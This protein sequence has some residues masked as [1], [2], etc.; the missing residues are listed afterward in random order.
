MGSMDDKWVRDIVEERVRKL[1]SDLAECLQ[2]VDSRLDSLEHIT[3]PWKNDSHG[4]DVQRKRVY[5]LNEQLARALDANGKLQ[6]ERDAA[7][8]RVKELEAQDDFL[9]VADLEAHKERIARELKQEHG[10]E[11]EKLRADLNASEKTNAALR[12][13]AEE[14]EARA[15]AAERTLE[16]LKNRIRTYVKDL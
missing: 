2:H 4:K 11:V 14:H 1:D 9:R 12:E 15:D 3:D 13:A 8:A 10:G 5:E 7:R 16:E 6:K